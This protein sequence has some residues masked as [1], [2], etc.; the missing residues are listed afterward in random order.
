MQKSK[1]KILVYTTLIVI[2]FYLASMLKADN[3]QT[4]KIEKIDLR[5][6]F[7]GHS[8]SEREKEFVNFLQ[9]YFKE[10]GKVDLPKFE[11]SQAK[12]FD[13]IIM[14]YDGRCFDAPRPKLSREYDRPTVTIAG[15][16]ALIG[17]SLNLKTGYL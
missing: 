12:D 9:S 5:I 16:G 15:I 1:I 8:G 4:N 2:N 10:V 11:E 14:D 3:P 17:S 6:L 13:V 7:A